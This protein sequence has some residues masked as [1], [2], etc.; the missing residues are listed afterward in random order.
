MTVM[1]VQMAQDTHLNGLS[2]VGRSNKLSF[3]YT[4][5]TT[6]TFCALI[7]QNANDRESDSQ[8]G[9]YSDMQ[10]NGGAEVV[11]THGDPAVEP[12]PVAMEDLHVNGNYELQER[13][14]QDKPASVWDRIK[15]NHRSTQN[16]K[17]GFAEGEEG[18]HFEN[19]EKWKKNGASSYRTGSGK[20]RGGRE[21][22]HRGGA[23]HPGR[24][25]L[26]SGQILGDA[27]RRINT[28]HMQNSDNLYKRNG[29]ASNKLGRHRPGNESSQTDGK[30]I[31]DAQ[32]TIVNEVGHLKP[33]THS[34]LG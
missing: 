7:W 28:A 9:V 5:E 8:C 31:G 23:L 18:V 21:Q 15:F 16:N 14:T 17:N 13:Q 34:L 11:T 30:V 2:T 29:S 10:G 6:E 32:T 24:T 12:E 19:R 4:Y 20:G 33:F 3:I 22:R 26:V 1:V 27:L 25:V